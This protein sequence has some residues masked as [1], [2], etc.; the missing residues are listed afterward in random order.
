MSLKAPDPLAQVPETTARRGDITRVGGVS[1]EAHYF[2]DFFLGNQG[3]LD[4]PSDVTVKVSADVA[5]VDAHTELTRRD[6]V[7]Q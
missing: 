5:K 7:I 1:D 3:V 2:A 6:A 4:K